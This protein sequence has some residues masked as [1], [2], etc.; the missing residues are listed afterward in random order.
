MTVARMKFALLIVLVFAAR[1][2]AQDPGQPF[3]L[4]PGDFRW[5]PFTVRH[6][7]TEVEC[8]FEV[9]EGDPTVHIELLPM[10]EFGS[11]NRGEEHSTMA[12]TPSARTGDFRRVIDNRGRY[13]LVVVNA[14]NAPPVTVTLDLRTN[15]NPSNADVARTLPPR[16]RL[17]V[18]LISFAFFFVTVTWSSRK[19][20]R[21]MRMSG[22]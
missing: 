13:A 20:I 3:R 19:L 16:R 9:L 21:A 5:V 4:A 1:V 17:A 18:V 2:Q 15:V 7:P 11:F 6:T 10:S 8:R 12:L 14:K 22:R